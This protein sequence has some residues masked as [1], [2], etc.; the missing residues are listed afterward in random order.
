VA[1]V[2]KNNGETEIKE[3]EKMNR[4][5]VRLVAPLLCGVVLA[6]ALI[7][8]GS[9]NS[10][11]GASARAGDLAITDAYIP[12]PASPD[13]AVVYFTVKNNG[14]K[15]DALVGATSPVA[16]SAS[17]HNEMTMQ[18][19]SMMMPLQEIAIPAHQTVRLSVG[20]MHLM[21]ENLKQKLQ[22][23][24]RVQVTLQFKNAGSVTLTVP[25]TDI[26]GMSGM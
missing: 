4:R 18:G 7:G 13:V 2:G 26:G 23:G 6:F 3:I 24:Q 16:Q 10:T 11:K 20:G 17:L 8:C 5:Y 21:L 1:L 25:V 22:K 15:D 9:S 12:A 14:D 19:S